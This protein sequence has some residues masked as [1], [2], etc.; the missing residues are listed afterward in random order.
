M[1]IVKVGF[2]LVSPR[3]GVSFV[4][5]VPWHAHFGALLIFRAVRRYSIDG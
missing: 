3:Q 5:K 2:A 4:D 1:S